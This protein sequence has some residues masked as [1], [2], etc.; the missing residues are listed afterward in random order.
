[1][2][3]FRAIAAL[4]VFFVCAARLGHAA[5]IPRPAPDFAI[6]FGPGAKPIR[7]SE[8]RG[9]T[10]VLAVIL[11]YCSHCQAV[12]RGLIKDQQELGPKGLQI[13]AT[14]IDDPA[15]VPGFVKQFA[16]PFP[17][18][19]NTQ[20]EAFA[21]AQHPPMLIPYMPF[22]IFIDKD[23]VIRAQYQGRDPMLKL[24]TQEKTVREKI[25]EMLNPPKKPT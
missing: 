6:N 3:N 4:S 21:F 12:I 25:L 10:V 2:R 8:H 7:L 24:E 20:A 14:A 1:M 15:K 16:P 22:L 9:K 5:E 11:T 19:Y 18:G 23:G 13:V 17:V